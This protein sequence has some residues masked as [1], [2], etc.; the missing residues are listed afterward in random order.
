[1]EAQVHLPEV[2]TDMNSECEMPEDMREA[3]RIATQAVAQLSEHV[4]AV[5]IFIS[6]RQSCGKDGT[7]RGVFGAGNWFARYGQIKQW[8]LA[9]DGLAAQPLKANED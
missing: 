8:V 1:M 5:T 6:S 3:D 4:D 7:L 9:E 2:S